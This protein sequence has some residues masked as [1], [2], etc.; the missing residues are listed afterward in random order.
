MDIFKIKDMKGGW[1][2]GDFEPSVYKTKNFEVGVKTHPKGEIWDVH[3]HKKATEINY[4]LEG[5]MI[6]QNTELTTGD[7]F[8]LYP[9]EIANPTFLEDCTIVTVKSV[10]EI[11]DKYI[12]V[13]S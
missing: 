13:N 3:Y 6:L 12:I 7:I 5:K 4:L 9:N 8:V 2:V 11:G 10:S 1:F